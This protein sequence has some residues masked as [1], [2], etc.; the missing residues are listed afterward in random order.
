M[1]KL[2]IGHIL[3]LVEAILSV[4]TIIVIIFSVL[5]LRTRRRK[6]KV[7]YSV[8]W[9][10]SSTLKP[11]QILG[12]R[13]YHEYYYRRPEDESIVR[14]LEDRKNCLVVG[15]PL[16]GKSRAVFEGLTHSLVRFDVIIPK[17]VNIDPKDFVVPK[18]LRFWRPKLILI[19]DLQRYIELQNFDYIFMLAREKNVT[20]IATCRAGIDYTRVKN[21]MLEKNLGLEI[22]F[23]RNIFELKKVAREVGEKIAERVGVDWNRVKFD[24]NIGSIL[25]P[26]GEMEK[27]FD[28]SDNQLKTIL[29][30]IKILHRCGAYQ[31]NQIFPVEW[32][33]TLAQKY[34]LTGKAF[35]W[36]A[37]F[38]NL[39]DKEFITLARD[40]IWVEESYLESSVK[41]EIEISDFDMFDEVLHLFSAEPVVLSKVGHRAYEV[42]GVSL[43]KA[44]YMKVAIKAFE[45]ALDIC[46]VERFPQQY[47]TIQI[48]LGNAYRKLAEVEAKVDNCKRAI[49]ASQEALKVYALE[50]FPLDY[51]VAQNNLGNAYGTLAEVEAPADNCTRAIVAFEQALKV[52]TFE[53][54]PLDYAMTQ[55][56]LGNAYIGL[57]EVEGKADNCKRAIAAYGESM[58]VYT[59]ERFPLQYAATQHNLGS[60][61]SILAEVEA[62]ADN[63]RR[64]IDAYREALKAY[65]LERFPL[66]YAMTQYDL[67]NA[68]SALAEVEATADNCQRAIAAYEEALKVYTEEKFPEQ[69]RSVV[70]NHRKTLNLRGTPTPGSGVTS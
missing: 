39:R 46:T 2:D 24:G 58:K 5:E 36:I 37:W 48:S 4:L 23:G 62:K 35:E 15:S 54:L 40:A 33:K 19:D 41:F 9:E 68:H 31:E 26:L 29:R 16:S 3:F 13:P 50:S 67:G 69:Y 47:G 28:E 27:R 21:K 51:A 38:E 11:E 56:N 34:G 8:I 17:C 44:Q 22:V 61:Y 32:I 45:G 53:R 55:N 6:H 12:A 66:Q 1:N 52:R 70:D 30:T 57:A 49:E 59:F 64:A 25:M 60:A 7:F 20:I 18:H 63:C 42:G 14:S 65:T 10:K 43:E